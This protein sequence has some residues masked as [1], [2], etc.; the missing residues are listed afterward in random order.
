ML[1]AKSSSRPKRC[2]TSARCSW[3]AA[4]HNKNG[5]SLN[6]STA[7]SPKPKRSCVVAQ[8]GGAARPVAQGENR[9]SNQPLGA[10]K[11]ARP[12]AKAACGTASI[13]PSQRIRRAQ[14]GLEKLVESSQAASATASTVD[15]KPVQIV[16]QSEGRVC[17]SASRLCQAPASSAAWAAAA[18]AHASGKP[19]R[20]SSKVATA[21]WARMDLSN[22]K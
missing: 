13:G 10:I 21:S 1:R 6:T 4:A 8:G 2:A 22:R 7:I 14:A 17:E 3:V 5:T 9:R 11:A 19:S 18:T 20:A 16:S 12:I 15:A